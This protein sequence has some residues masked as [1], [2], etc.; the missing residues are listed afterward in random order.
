MNLA[1]DIFLIYFQEADYN[2]IN[3]R[4]YTRNTDSIL[5]YFLD[6]DNI[7]LR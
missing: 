1:F 3:P 4:G 7:F 6:Q 2:P 5:F